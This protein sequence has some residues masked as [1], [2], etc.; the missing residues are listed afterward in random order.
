MKI[1]DSKDVDVLLRNILKN[2][3]LRKFKSSLR[4]NAPFTKVT[5]RLF[6]AG[7][8]N[9][10]VVCYSDLVLLSDAEITNIYT[11]YFEGMADCLNKGHAFTSLGMRK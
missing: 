10:L 5:V 2:L 9:E 7:L 1:R 6:K 8:F 4:H 11:A 3:K